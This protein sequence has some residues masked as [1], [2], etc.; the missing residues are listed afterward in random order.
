MSASPTPVQKLTKRELDMISAVVNGATNREIS[1]QFGVSEQT[2]NNHLSNVFDKVGVS[3]RLELAL[4]VM[5][6]KLLDRRK[7]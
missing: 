4:Y 6:H 2:V 7:K 1:R 5:H 3:N